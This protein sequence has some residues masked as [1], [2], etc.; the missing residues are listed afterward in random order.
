M[1]TAST[2]SMQSA[3]TSDN[4]YSVMIPDATVPV[5]ER[6]LD[7]FADREGWTGKESKTKDGVTTISYLTSKS[8][9][10]LF[11]KGSVDFHLSQ[12]SESVLAETSVK[13]SNKK[14]RQKALSYA[15]TMLSSEDGRTFLFKEVKQSVYEKNNSPLVLSIILVAFILGIVSG[16]HFYLQNSVVKATSDKQYDAQRVCDLAKIQY[17]LEVGYEKNHTYPEDIY[18]VDFQNKYRTLFPGESFVPKDP[19][20]NISYSYWRFLADRYKL[21]GILSN[22]STPTKDPEVD[23]PGKNHAL[24]TGDYSNEFSSL[25]AS[26]YTYPCSSLYL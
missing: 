22:N 4:E 16:W 15:K 19:E 2:N 26:I 3:N 18:H 10:S 12:V 17:A 24:K 7:H 23:F 25:D 5:V 9:I 11:G 21:S 13:G 6:S 20:S 14:V 8:G 1:P